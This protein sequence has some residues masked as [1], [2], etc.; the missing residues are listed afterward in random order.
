MPVM[1]SALPTVRLSTNPAASRMATSTREVT[2]SLPE[3]S[4]ELVVTVRGSRC[5]LSMGAVPFSEGADGR[6]GTGYG[7]GH[8]EDKKAPGQPGS[9]CGAYA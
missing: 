2:S 1:A 9:R 4:L 7:R 5:S 3:R 6:A 8:G